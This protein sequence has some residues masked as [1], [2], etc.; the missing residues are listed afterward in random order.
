[1]EVTFIVRCL[2]GELEGEITLL[3]KQKKNITER[4]KED[5]EPESLVCAVIHTVGLLLM[6]RNLGV[7]G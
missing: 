2:H 1:M 5:R 6:Q 7:G 4:G 3:H